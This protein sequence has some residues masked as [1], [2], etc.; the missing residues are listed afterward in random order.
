MSLF[1]ARDW[2][3]VKCG[4]DETFETNHMCI[5]KCDQ[6]GKQFITVASVDGYLRIY[7][8]QAGS[9]HCTASLVI[10]TKLSSDVIAVQSGRFTK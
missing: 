2:W 1:K 8:P 9:D 5:A 7:D 4:E 6:T 10:E 3:S